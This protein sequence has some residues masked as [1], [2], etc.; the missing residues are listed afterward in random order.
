MNDGD[1]DAAR[2]G[3]SNKVPNKRDSLSDIR[4]SPLTN[5][6]N[7]DDN[8][9]DDND[10][11]TSS[12]Q[13]VKK[14]GYYV[15]TSKPKSPSLS[16]KFKLYADPNVSFR[17]VVRLYL[18]QLTKRQNTTEPTDVANGKAARNETISRHVLAS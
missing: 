2:L 16:K 10:E 9:N 14:A 4:P 6:H 1:N 12:E 17:V 3:N 15:I 13:K 5:N 7:D 18:T 8:D 11:D